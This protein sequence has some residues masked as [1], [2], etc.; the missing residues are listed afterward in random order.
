MVH[1]NLNREISQT[2][3]AHTW[4]MVQETISQFTSVYMT[5]GRQFV[6]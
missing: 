1:H 3:A 6:K 2:S 4:A 5:K